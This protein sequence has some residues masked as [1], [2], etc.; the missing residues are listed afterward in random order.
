[1]IKKGRDMEREF[2]ERMR[3]G[4][5]T[6]E[7]THIF[8]KEELRGKVRLL[9]RL[10]LPKGSSIGYHVHE[11]EEEV[12][13]ILSGRGVVT[14]GQ[15]VS[16]VEPGDAVLTGGGGGHSIENREQTPLEL[17]ATILTY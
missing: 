13:Y 14:E 9:A 4:S 3:E 5:G 15:V 11:G 1:M 8:K 6:V 7:I 2:R 16:P 12:F 17:L 10:R